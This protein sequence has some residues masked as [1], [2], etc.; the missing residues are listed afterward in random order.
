M[1]EHS[2]LGSLPYEILFKIALKM[3]STSVLFFCISDERFRGLCDDEYFWA[4]KSNIDFGY[5]IDL[6]NNYP[7]IAPFERYTLVSTAYDYSQKITLLN[8]DFIHI[9][10]TN[11]DDKIKIIS[12]NKGVNTRTTLNVDLTYNSP[13]Y[14]T[15]IIYYYKNNEAYLLY[16]R[17]LIHESIR[18]NDI[19]VF[20]LII[21]SGIIAPNERTSELLRL[22][23]VN[24]RYE[25]IK[26]LLMY[27][28][29]DPN[30]GHF[31]LGALAYVISGQKSDRISDY[32]RS[33]YLL[34]NDPRTNVAKNDNITIYEASG[35][36]NV[37]MIKVLL[38]HPDV[39]PSDKSNRAIVHSID[40]GHID[41]FQLLLENV[42]I[43]DRDIDIII[44]N[45]IN[46]CLVDFL[47]ILI[48]S[49]KFYLNDNIIN[50]IRREL[51]RQMCPQIR[52][53]L[54]NLLTY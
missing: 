39:N 8:G 10:D 15:A 1:S 45:I 12:M 49:P 19:E 18:N 31:Q 42:T 14:I 20:D 9:L 29:V 25:I 43:S 40:K 36:G 17:R 23:A 50:I 6:F 30:L 35:L 53:I 3:D 21:N 51:E 27:P 44:Y 13:F 7:D 28:E 34:L 26:K 16:I 11:D 46:K 2:N 54:E 5:P 48:N 52:T 24:G 37:D 32:W 47:E 41:A 22:A 4:T 38:S 33:F